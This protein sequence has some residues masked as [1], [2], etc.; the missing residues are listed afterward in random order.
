MGGS[1][2]ATAKKRNHI[3]KSLGGGRPGRCFSPDNK[4]PY[5]PH[6]NLL[7]VTITR[8]QNGTF[9]AIPSIAPIPE[10]LYI[11]PTTLWTGQNPVFDDMPLFYQKLFK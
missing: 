11:P 8:S 3:K 2:D 1:T 6:Q 10:T 7:P 4:R 9:T 5:P